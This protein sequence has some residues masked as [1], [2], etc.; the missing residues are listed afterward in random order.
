M[1]IRAC[2]RVRKPAYWIDCML[3]NVGAD[4]RALVCVFASSCAQVT[5]KYEF[6]RVSY[7]GLTLTP[8]SNYHIQGLYNHF[9]GMFNKS[10]VE[11]VFACL[12]GVA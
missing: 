8:S 10:F 7:F 5:Y 12:Q 1:R 3:E 2:V 4:I 9:P 11:I 6:L